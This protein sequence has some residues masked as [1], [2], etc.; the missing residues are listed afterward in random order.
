MISEEDL[1]TI[2]KACPGAI[3]SEEI[4]HWP[5]GTHSILVQ[6]GRYHDGFAWAVVA[7]APTLEKAFRVAKKN[8]T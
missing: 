4:T 8:W 7:R 2:R 1:A 3:V 6:I 5:D